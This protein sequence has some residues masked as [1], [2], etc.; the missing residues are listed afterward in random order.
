MH[1][2]INTL[3]FC[4][5]MMVLKENRQEINQAFKIISSLYDSPL[6]VI[7]DQRESTYQVKEL[8][9]ARDKIISSFLLFPSGGQVIKERAPTKQSIEDARDNIISS[10]L[11]PSG[12]HF[13]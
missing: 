10:L 5:P 6:A 12:G 11:F 4:P 2:H 1:V 3:S 7:L 9:D 8:E 13:Q